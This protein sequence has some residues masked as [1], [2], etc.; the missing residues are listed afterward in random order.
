MNVYLRKFKDVSQEIRQEK[1]YTKVKVLKI[2]Q[3][4]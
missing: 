3:L 1:G 4:N 2:R